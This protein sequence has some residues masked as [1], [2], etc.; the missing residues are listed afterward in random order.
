[1]IDVDETRNKRCQ[2]L[3]ELVIS[4]RHRGHSLWL[5]TQSYTAVPNNI[6][7]Q[8]KM[9]YVWY[10]KNRTDLNTIHE[11]NDV[12]GPVEL[13]RVKAQLTQGKHTCLIMRMEH[14]R[15]YMIR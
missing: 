8:A 7:R 9:L 1:M 3:L 5:L 13:A 2:P 12:V 10:P 15:A 11:E 6:R 14:P 4:G